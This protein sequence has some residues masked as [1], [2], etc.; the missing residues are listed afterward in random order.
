[1]NKNMRTKQNPGMN[2]QVPVESQVI[3]TNQCMS[4]NKIEH[5]MEL[6]YERVL[7][8]RKDKVKKGELEEKK[9]LQCQQRKKVCALRRDRINR[10]SRVSNLNGLKWLRSI[11]GHNTVNVDRFWTV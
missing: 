9:K 11:T 5:M 8:P 10:H 4:N 7:K 2:N 3:R 6:Y 1:M